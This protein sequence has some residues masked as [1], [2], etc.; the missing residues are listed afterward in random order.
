MMFFVLVSTIILAKGSKEKDA[1]KYQ[2][3]YP[4]Y[5]VCASCI[6]GK[7]CSISELLDESSQILPLICYAV[8]DQSVNLS[9]KLCLQ[10]KRVGL[11][12]CYQTAF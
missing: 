12:Q 6:H 5:V 9:G 1:E 7:E 4:L 3:L 11:N 2:L 10:I 8:L